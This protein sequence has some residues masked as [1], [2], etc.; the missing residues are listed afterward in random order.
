MQAGQYYTRDD[1]GLVQRWPGRVWLNPPYARE[2]V[3]E[4][5]GKLLGSEFSQA[6]VLVN[7]STE[8]IWAQQ[9]LDACV[10]VCFPLKRVRFT[11]PAYVSGSQSKDR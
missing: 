8:T 2:L 1:D 4:F 3:G 9:L 10:S 6:C 7:N 5:V 11:G